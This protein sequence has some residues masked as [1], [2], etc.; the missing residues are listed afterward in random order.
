MGNGSIPTPQASETG[1]AARHR[2][3][4]LDRQARQGRYAPWHSGPHPRTAAFDSPRLPIRSRNPPNAV[5]GPHD[6]STTPSFSS[7]GAIQLGYA[8]GRCVTR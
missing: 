6:R 2:L 4:H 1:Q 5:P 7:E 3:V 8:V